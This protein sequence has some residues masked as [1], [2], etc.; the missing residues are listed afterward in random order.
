MDYDLC[1]KRDELQKQVR[2][3]LFFDS[4]RH[5]EI[6]GKV[7]TKFANHVTNELKGA[8]CYFLE[9]FPHRSNS[10]Y[11]KMSNKISCMACCTNSLGIQAKPDVSTITGDQR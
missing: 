1:K 9:G 3:H 2:P 4:Q 8:A 6:L 11:T 10:S 5:I 7:S